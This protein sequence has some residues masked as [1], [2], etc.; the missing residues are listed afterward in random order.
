MKNAEVQS[1]P[2]AQKPS[3]IHD[4]LNLSN[5]ELGKLTLQDLDLLL[6][7][8]PE[9][10]D[11]EAAEQVK[12]AQAKMMDDFRG[13]TQEFVNNLKT[14]LEISKQKAAAD[15]VELV[16]AAKKR[17]ADENDKG[18]A[19]PTCPQAQQPQQAPPAAAAAAAMPAQPAPDAAEETAAAAKAKADQTAKE[20]QSNKAKELANQRLLEQ[21]RQQAAA[22]QKP[23][24]AAS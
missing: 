18:C 17:N 19:Q 16:Q 1:S 11:T 7:V 4:I 23:A 20:Q 2:S 14:H 9:E 6:E 24:T 15:R 3:L 12:I 22:A 5:E 21:A 8:N 13:K 10:L